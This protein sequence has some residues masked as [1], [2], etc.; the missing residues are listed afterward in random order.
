MY[1]EPLKTKEQ[2]EVT[3][4]FQRIQRVARGRLLGKERAIPSNFTTDSGAEF[5][6]P[7]SELL[8][9][10]GISQEFKEAQNSMA[11]VDAAIRTIKTSIAKEMVETESDS[12]AKALPFAV[13]A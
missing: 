8:E 1:A 13:K 2:E 11:V 12:W 6:V 5:K 4:A 9:K 3:E 10:Q 7:F